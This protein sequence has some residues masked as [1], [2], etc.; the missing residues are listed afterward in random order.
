MGSSYQPGAEVGS[1]L[2]QGW[3]LFLQVSVV[4]WLVL[5]GCGRHYLCRTWYCDRVVCVF[6]SA[7]ELEL[8]FAW[9]SL[10]LQVGP[11]PILVLRKGGMVVP[12]SIFTVAGP[13][14]LGSFWCTRRTERLAEYRL[15]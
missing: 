10:P 9:G 1:R 15:S 14:G 2:A 3:L 4:Q 13:C 11:D 7:R 12:T 6:D 8:T 5:S